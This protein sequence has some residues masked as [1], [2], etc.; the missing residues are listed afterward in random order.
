M[1]RILF[2]LF[3][4]CLVLSACK[5]E[6][7][8]DVLDNTVWQSGQNSENT[9]GAVSY[10]SIFYG[11][12]SVCREIIEFQYGFAERYYT[13]NGEKV[14][15]FPGGE[16]E[17]NGNTLII[18]KDTAHTYQLEENTIVSYHL[19]GRVNGVFYKIK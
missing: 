17:L 14:K 4:G 12:G 8:K 7:E 2:V 15:Y 11:D 5:K 9:D 16:Y 3:A 10:G 19:D 1:K 18:P 6:E 13:H